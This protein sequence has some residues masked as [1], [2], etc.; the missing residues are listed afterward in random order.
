MLSWIVAATSS[1]C[2]ILA[3]LLPFDSIAEMGISEC[4]M[5]VAMS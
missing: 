2:E 1:E 4:C 5:D 3:M